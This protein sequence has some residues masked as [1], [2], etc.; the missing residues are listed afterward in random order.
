MKN[1]L[2]QN[3]NNEKA[4]SSKHRLAAWGRLLPALR[5]E[6]NKGG[7]LISKRGSEVIIETEEWLDD[8]EPEACA[9]CELSLANAEA[10]NLCDLSIELAQIRSIKLKGKLSLIMRLYKK[11]NEPETVAELMD[12]TECNGEHEV[13]GLI[14]SQQFDGTADYV[15][16]GCP[17]CNAEKLKT[18][19][20]ELTECI[21]GDIALCSSKADIAVGEEGQG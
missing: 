1:D 14:Y 13:M 9:Q 8:A 17:H 5:F 21:E 7:Q 4:R 15:E 6:P 10:C 3:K 18:T 16:N 11:Y 19:V 2:K 12:S 20:R